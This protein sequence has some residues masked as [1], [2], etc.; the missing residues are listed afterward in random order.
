MQGGGRGSI[1]SER[2]KIPRA[3][4]PNK[5]NIK[6]KVYYNKFNKDVNDGPH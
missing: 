6:Q 4:W 2:A 5:Q 1:P 3:L